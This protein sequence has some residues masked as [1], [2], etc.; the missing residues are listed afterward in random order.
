MY[1]EKEKSDHPFASDAMKEVIGII[2]KQPSQFYLKKAQG[3]ASFLERTVYQG[4]SHRFAEVQE[5]VFL[6]L[7][8]IEYDRKQLVDEETASEDVNRKELYQRGLL[9]YD[10]ELKKIY[11]EEL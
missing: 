5:N 9:L 8:S 2:N 1:P 11:T 7:K 3:A 6:A 10:I 4:I